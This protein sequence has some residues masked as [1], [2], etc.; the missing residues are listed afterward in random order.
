M[1][2][3]NYKKSEIIMF[4]FFNVKQFKSSLIS[5]LKHDCNPSN[6]DMLLAYGVFWTSKNRPERQGILAK[7]SLISD[8]IYQQ[9]KETDKY[10]ETSERFLQGS[11]FK[12]IKLLPFFVY[13][14]GSIEEVFQI[15]GINEKDGS[16]EIICNLVLIKRILGENNKTSDREDVERLYKEYRENAKNLNMGLVL[17]KKYFI[18]VLY[19]MK[20]FYLDYN[21][22]SNNS[23]QVD[24]KAYEATHLFNNELLFGQDKQYEYSLRVL[25][26]KLDN[27][28]LSKIDERAQFY[29]LSIREWRETIKRIRKSILAVTPLDILCAIAIS[30][31]TEYY[32]KSNLRLKKRM[33]KSGLR[34]NYIVV[35]NGLVYQAFV[36]MLEFKKDELDEIYIFSPSPFFI[37]TFAE[38]S[39][40]FDKTINFVVKNRH[41]KE[42]LELHFSNATNSEYIRPN[43][44]FCDYSE[45]E[46]NILNSLHMGKVG[47]LLFLDNDCDSAIIEK[48]IKTHL[49]RMESVY[50][51]SSDE[52]MQSVLS[53]GVKIT[54]ILFLPRGIWGSASPKLRAFWRTSNLNMEDN[55]DSMKANMVIGN[56]I[57]EK[58]GKHFISISERKIIEVP[59]SEI[60]YG[61]NIFARTAYRNCLNGIKANGNSRSL[62]RSCSFSPEID[63]W[64]TMTPYKGRLDKVRIEAYA[65]CI[66]ESDGKNSQKLPRGKVIENSIKRAS[67]SAENV[68]RWIK[69]EYPFFQVH[70]RDG[71]KSTR[72]IRE[73]VAEQYRILL[74][75]KKISLRTLWYIY[76]ELELNY[77]EK[78][79]HTLGSLSLGDIGEIK[80]DDFTEEFGI[81]LYNG[82]F[83]NDSEQQVTR[84]ISIIA[85]AISFA[86]SMGHCNTN[87]LECLLIGQ[88]SSQLKFRQIR[89][90]LTKKT[91]TRLEYQ[92]LYREVQNKISKGH[93]EYIGIL[94][95]LMMGIESNVICALE[96]D[97]IEYVPEYDFYKLLIYKQVTNDGTE[98]RDLTS[99]NDYRC[100]PCS[101]IL[102]RV[103]HKEI[104]QRKKSNPHN[105]KHTRLVTSNR[106]TEFAPKELDKLAKALV[107]RIGI[108]DIVVKV[109]D[110]DKGTKE[111]N[112]SVYQGDIFRMSFQAWAQSYSKLTGDEVNYLLGNNP[113]TTFGLH[114]CDFANNSSQLVMYTKLRRMDT[115]MEKEMSGN[116]DGNPNDDGTESV[117]FNPK[118]ELPV[119]ISMVVSVDPQEEKELKIS[120]QYGFTMLVTKHDE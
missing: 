99:M 104:E 106:K 91:L 16:D 109:P 41:Y 111:A 100:I 118:N 120:N 34:P 56:L 22:F 62:P 40:G 77:S 46:N 19:G 47:S 3:C 107:G 11:I 6:E 37:K 78:N 23:F 33:T 71:Q 9:D 5:L 2:S 117:V 63:F 44:F 108:D 79:Y 84:K 54:D 57:V 101:G 43:Y 31:K 114:Y 32:T 85:K 27:D 50:A 70:S 29:E 12:F 105:Y 36:D 74:N 39:F 8:M 13:D 95:K 17:E 18:R 15:N 92:N 112:L 103:L 1:Y 94:T 55:K 90:A 113:T 38:D 51:L 72:S 83:E 82:I 65:C 60:Y 64:Y 10:I 49:P 20:G 88:S 116:E 96:L 76:P 110:S 25:K 75:N 66:Y 42:L 48:I 7:M 86:I 45:V 89:S 81:N 93:S 59:I 52:Y 87:Q 115:I 4:D 119:R 24:P 98:V 58:S 35:E 69:E 67:I 21:M 61:K 68:D 26:N 80:L 53:K 30:K 28:K 14:L 97:D 73:V 102:S